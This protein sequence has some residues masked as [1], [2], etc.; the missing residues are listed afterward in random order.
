MET[1]KILIEAFGYLGS[2]LVL[3]SFLMVSVF[4]LRVVNSIGS[5]I[6]TIYAFIIH[7]Y[8][9]AIMNAC[10]V[11]INIYYLIKMSN[12]KKN[13]D[14]V[15]S[16]TN[17]SLL[18]YTID[19]YKEDIIKCFPGIN[20]DF[21]TANSGYVVCHNGKP[22]GIMLGELKD[23]VMEVL[24]DYSIPE[25][26]D[27]SIGQFLFSKLPEDGIKSLTYRGSDENHKAYLT[28]T[29]FVNMGGYYEKTF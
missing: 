7:S 14:L 23:G 6:F 26:R 24:L 2:A 28:K 4:K 18:K 3:V 21:A 13:Y 16:D 19:K 22:A 1:S 20:M 29:G 8:P 17:D 12:T 25:Y 5:I 11:M 10:L 27:F 15:K 9:T